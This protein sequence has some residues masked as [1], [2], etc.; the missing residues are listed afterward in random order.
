MRDKSGMPG[1]V[2]LKLVG[3]N[4]YVRKSDDPKWYL[5][6]YNTKVCK[7]FVLRFSDEYFSKLNR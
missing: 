5:V 3:N 2:T 4:N 1:S 6:Y 7:V